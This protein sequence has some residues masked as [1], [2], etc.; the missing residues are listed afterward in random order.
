MESSGVC[1]K[2]EKAMEAGATTY[3]A[4]GR[5]ELNVHT[6]VVVLSSMFTQR[7]WR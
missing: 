3:I 1:A 5:V 2:L 6:E 4:Q 7:L